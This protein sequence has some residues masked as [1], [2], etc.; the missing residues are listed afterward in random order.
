M[1]KWNSFVEGMKNLTPCQQ[2]HAKMVSYAGGAIGLVLALIT[3]FFR[4]L[5]Y[6][7]IFMF[8]MIVLQVVEFIGARQR[9][10]QALKIQKNI[11]MRERLN[12]IVNNVDESQ[13]E[14]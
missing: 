13:E 3:M 11:E 4:G 12:E 6:F 10:V 9:Y 14:K 2:L 8:F 7:S 5:W 1:N